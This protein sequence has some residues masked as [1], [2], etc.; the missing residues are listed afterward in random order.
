MS[1][2]VGTK[3]VHSYYQFG[4]L[5]RFPRLGRP[6]FRRMGVMKEYAIFMCYI[7]WYNTFL[8]SYLVVWPCKKKSPALVASLFCFYLLTVA[9][10]GKY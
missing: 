4:T 6:F 1:G 8:K 3:P 10:M 7:I 9:L 5:T 2:V